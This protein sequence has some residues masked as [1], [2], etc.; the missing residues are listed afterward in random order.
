M[1]KKNYLFLVTMLFSCV[2]PLEDVVDDGIFIRSDTCA[3]SS[4]QSE[5]QETG[6]YRDSV[7]RIYTTIVDYEKIE[8][9]FTTPLSG[10][11]IAE[12]ASISIDTYKQNNYKSY[13]RLYDNEFKKFHVIIT[14]TD[15]EFAYLYDPELFLKDKEKAL[16]VGYKY[17]AFVHTRKFCW[18]SVPASFTIVSRAEFAD[19]ITM[20]HEFGHVVSYYEFGDSDPGHKDPRIWITVGGDKSI[21]SKI[22]N[23][24][25]KIKNDSQEM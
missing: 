16:K 10:K 18:D 17:I 3:G 21:N 7:N 8:D 23:N 4:Y 2:I 13:K 6:I 22:L 20:I 12:L 1:F 14:H 11:D 25:I 24:F 9:R 19:H 5:Y 15:E